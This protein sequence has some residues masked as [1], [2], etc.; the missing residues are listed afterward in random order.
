[1]SPN[2]SA[3]SLTLA[4]LEQE[5]M[6]L[7]A[8]WRQEALSARTTRLDFMALVAALAE[9]GM[10]MSDPERKAYLTA[11]EGLGA[12]IRRTDFEVKTSVDCR[13]VADLAGESFSSREFQ[14]AVATRRERINTEL[15][16]R[17][18]E[19]TPE[20]AATAPADPPARK[21]WPW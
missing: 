20:P 19:P 13:A 4:G 14:L 5:F 6:G 11:A 10:A 21:R 15:A 1:M 8:R 3:Q 7:T 9:A 2:E 17:A 16:A 12:A 18:A